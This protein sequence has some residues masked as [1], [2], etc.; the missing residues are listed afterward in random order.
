MTQDLS[1]L[2]AIGIR[3]VF[4]GKIQL[5]RELANLAFGRGNAGL[6]RSDDAGLDFL[7][8]QLTTIE[9]GQPKLDEV[10]GD[11]MAAHRGNR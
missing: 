10:G 5:H 3:G 11:I 2:L 9:L 4:F 1:L 7:V 6:I 8:R